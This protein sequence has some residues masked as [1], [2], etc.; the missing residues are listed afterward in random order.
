MEVLQAKAEIARARQRIKEIGADAADAAIIAKLKRN[1]LWPGKPLGDQVKSWDV[2]KTVSFLQQNLSPAAAV[3]D[4]GAYCCEILP[5]LHR[6]GFTALTGVDLNPTLTAM[7]HSDSIN[8]LVGDFLSTNLADG[9]FD[10]ITAISV[11]EHGYQPER[12]FGEVARL[13][14]PG[15]F[16]LAS[17]DYWPEKIDTAQVKVFGLDWLI[18][19]RQD[20]EQMFAVAGTHGLDPVGAVSYAAGEPLISWQSRDYTFAWVAMRK[21]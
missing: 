10:A 8:Y 9:T 11:I 14:K 15:G 16:F 2:W 12:L 3:L 6:L 21:R 13:L 17:I 4:L 20:V 5:A 18:F 7:P 1:R 19:S